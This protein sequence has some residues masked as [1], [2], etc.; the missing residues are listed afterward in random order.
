MDAEGK[1]V[2]PCFIDIHAHSDFTLPLNPKADWKI[3]QGVTTELL[4][5][6]ASR[7]RRRRRRSKSWRTYL[8]GSALWLP[9]EMAIRNGEPRAEQR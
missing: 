4:V 6:A 7:W 1:I 5:I 8:F 3:R 2:T 9:F